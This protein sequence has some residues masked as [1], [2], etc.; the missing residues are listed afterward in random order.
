M[1]DF[2][3]QFRNLLIMATIAV[4]VGTGIIAFHPVLMQHELY[5]IVFNA[6]DSIMAHKL[7]PY[8]TAVQEN[9]LSRGLG[10]AFLLFL[11]LTWI[12]TRRMSQ[13]TR[14]QVRGE[15]GSYVYG[16]IFLM[17][18]IAYVAQPFASH[19][20]RLHMNWIIGIIGSFLA[21]L[22]FMPQKKIFAFLF[23]TVMIV[24]SW[25]LWSSYRNADTFLGKP[26]MVRIDVSEAM[27]QLEQLRRGPAH[28][29][30]LTWR[31]KPQVEWLQ[32]ATLPN[33]QP[34]WL[35]PGDIVR[36]TADR[37]PDIQVAEWTELPS[38]K[39][40]WFNQAT[41]FAGT[42]SVADFVD[43]VR[44]DRRGAQK[45]RLLNA[46]NDATL[47]GLQSCV[48]PATTA[49]VA[50]TAGVTQVGEEGI[51]RITNGGFLQ[52]VLNVRNYYPKWY[53]SGQGGDL[54]ITVW[55][56]RSS[57]TPPAGVAALLGER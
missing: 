13:G 3:A 14:E 45:R 34:V 46:S 31:Y 8:I 36:I 15:G 28:E 33:G 54:H 26:G 41:T 42:K 38:G 24:C 4:V 52:F 9:A 56:R 43:A 48:A 47:Y 27:A 7:L 17:L 39:D 1:R 16:G 55:S 37:H 51:F 57:L 18:L 22:M 50:L 5:R 29:H 19:A 20:M 21:M 2:R 25:Q 32:R 53:G 49:D 12:M 10:G 6:T 30:D 40:G 44:P 11:L 23:M 35:E